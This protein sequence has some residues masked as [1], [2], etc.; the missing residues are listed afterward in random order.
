MIAEE[1]ATEKDE[2]IYKKAR[3]NYFTLLE[4]ISTLADNLELTFELGFGEE[5]KEK[6]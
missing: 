4:A 5:E 1:S 2:E 3:N 6:R